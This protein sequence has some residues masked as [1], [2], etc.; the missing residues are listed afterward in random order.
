MSMVEKYNCIIGDFVWVGVDY[1]GEA[2][3]GDWTYYSYKGLPIT[4]G[5]GVLDLTLNE[6]KRLTKLTNIYTPNK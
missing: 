1:L 6:T 4:S 5:S 2:G 3:F